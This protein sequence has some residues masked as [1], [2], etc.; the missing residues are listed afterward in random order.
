MSRSLPFI[1]LFSVSLLSPVCQTWK[2]ALSTSIPWYY[3]QLHRCTSMSFQSL[4]DYIDIQVSILFSHQ[5]HS[6]Y[7]HFDARL[8][9]RVTSIITHFISPTAFLFLSAGLK[10]ICVD[11]CTLLK[12]STS[13]NKLPGSE[14]SSS[15][16]NGAHF[17]GRPLQPLWFVSLL[18]G[19]EVPEPQ[20]ICFLEW[21]SEREQPASLN[22][23]KKR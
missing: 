14:R 15:E 17:T 2:L 1:F 7:L 5:Y 6:N 16:T 19:A 10:S 11:V 21:Q 13:A 12:D 4:E 18:M 9:K 23:F 20:A 3:P 22:S 8:S